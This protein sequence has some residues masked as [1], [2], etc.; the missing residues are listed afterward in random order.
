MDNCRE[1]MNYTSSGVIGA[2]STLVFIQWD[3]AIEALF[4]GGMGALG[5]LIIRALWGV[6]IG[7]LKMWRKNK[8]I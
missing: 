8:K 5:A 6:G 3:A 2:I 1:T 7:A 4:Y